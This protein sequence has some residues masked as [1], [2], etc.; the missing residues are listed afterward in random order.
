MAPTRKRKHSDSTSFS[1]SDSQLEFS[2][3]E[4][5]I[6]GALTGKKQ[7]SI[8]T[9][10]TDADEEDIEQSDYDDDELRDVIGKSLQ[11]RNVRGGTELLRR[12]KGRTKISTGEVGGGSFQ[13]M[14]KLIS[15]TIRL[16]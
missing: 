1:S 14:G 11:K 6:S 7:V 16:E 8:F 3:D 4:V 10:R 9:N 2:D 13:S 12:T 5:D 15:T